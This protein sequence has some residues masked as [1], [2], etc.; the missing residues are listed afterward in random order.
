L[1]PRN[2]DSEWQKNGSEWLAVRS[3]FIAN[4]REERTRHPQF[5]PVLSESSAAPSE[6]RVARDGSRKYESDL[7]IVRD[8][9]PAVLSG[10]RESD[11]ESIASSRRFRIVR[12]EFRASSRRFIVVPSGSRKYGSGFRIAGEPFQVAR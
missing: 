5:R 1:G 9:L 4:D 7:R 6:F 10:S 2:D 3:D 12:D 8:E 11:P